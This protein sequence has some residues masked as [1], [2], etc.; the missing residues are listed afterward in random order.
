MKLLTTSALLAVLPLGTSAFRHYIS[1]Y[2]RVFCN[3]IDQSCT[4][5]LDVVYADGDDSCDAVKNS[6]DY[7]TNDFTKGGSFEWPATDNHAK[8]T[9]H[10]NDDDD[11]WKDDKGARVGWAGYDS[12]EWYWLYVHW[13]RCCE[14]LYPFDTR[15][16]FRMLTFG[17]D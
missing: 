3:P 7:Y 2:N 17:D 8:F 4:P 9:L 15:F 16:V 12:G 13:G 1:E 6:V 10:F 14:D 5:T 11:W